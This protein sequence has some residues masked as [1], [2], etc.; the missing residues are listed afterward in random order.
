MTILVNLEIG[1][2]SHEDVLLAIDCDHWH[3]AQHVHRGLRL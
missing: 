2:A 1:I 3:L